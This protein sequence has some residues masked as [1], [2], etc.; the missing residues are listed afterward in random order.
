MEFELSSVSSDSTYASDY[1]GIC[2]LQRG[3]YN[4]ETD[5]PPLLP[6]STSIRISACLSLTIHDALVDVLASPS[7]T[8]F[9]CW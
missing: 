2:V 3:S 9:V 6:V 5:I 4:R 8:L 7:I 1:L